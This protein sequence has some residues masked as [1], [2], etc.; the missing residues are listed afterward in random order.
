MK[1]WRK[2]GWALAIFAGFLL[3][4]VLVGSL[5]LNGFVRWTI[6]VGMGWGIGITGLGLSV[7]IAAL[8]FAA[9]LLRWLAFRH[10]GREFAAAVLFATGCA[11]GFMPALYT[12][13][14]L[15]FVTAKYLAARSAPVT[16]ALEAYVANEK[17]VPKSLA[18]LVPN[19]LS[20]VPWTGSSLYPDYVLLTGADAPVGNPW[21]LTIEMYAALKWDALYYCPRQNCVGNIG[22][23]AGI[24]VGDWVFLDE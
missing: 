10:G 16:A 24:P 18:E 22:G 17:R 6:P 20:D 11:L 2:F 12:G 14:H 4:I 5:W 13:Y 1:I 21:I 19:Y 23:G 7:V 8:L 9:T 3:P 15:K